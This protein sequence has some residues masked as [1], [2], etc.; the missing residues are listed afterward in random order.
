MA[1]EQEGGRTVVV[2]LTGGIGAGKS[3]VAGILRNHGVAV[4]DTD[5]VARD[6]IEPG[7]PAYEAVVRAFGPGVVAG[8]GAIDRDA[9]ADRVF[10]SDEDRARLNAIVHPAVRE[11]WERWMAERRQAGESAVVVIPLLFEVGA[12]EG[13][14]AILCVTA[15]EEI[16]LERLR[17]RGW[18]DGESRRRMAAQ[19]APAEKRDRSDFSIENNTTLDHLEREVMETWR[20]MKNKE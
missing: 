1:P 16:A 4:L 18:T 15:D 10:R 6:A 14:D 2:G 13:W 20:R 11:V 8:D 12:T 17:A 9:L 7:G 3:T 5:D 19:W